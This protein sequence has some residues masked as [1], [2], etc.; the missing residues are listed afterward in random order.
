MLYR[1]ALL[2]AMALAWPVGHAQGTPRAEDAPVLNVSALSREALSAQ[3]REQLLQ[4]RGQ[5][6]HVAAIQQVGMW[7]V[8]AQFDTPPRVQA[9]VRALGVDAHQVDVSLVTQEGEPAPGGMRF[10]LR[11]P[12]PVWVAAQPLSRGDRLQCEAFRRE[13]RIGRSPRALL[14]DA[15]PGGEPSRLKRPL[16]A[17]EVLMA[18]D[19][20]PLGAVQE[21]QAARVTVRVGAI[22]VEATGVAL[23]DAQVGQVS[24]VKVGTSAAVLRAV[25]VA[26]GELRLGESVQ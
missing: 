7:R 17:G 8:P 25:V 18:S 22:Q 12:M 15:C 10:V 6:G 3:V 13:W 16:A 14:A 5:G 2:S 26:P 19:V 20:A 24:S 11:D 23:A 21:Q 9:S 1:L 4:W